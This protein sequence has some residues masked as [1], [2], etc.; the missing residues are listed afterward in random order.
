MWKWGVTG[1]QAGVQKNPWNYSPSAICLCT[2][3]V[4]LCIKCPSR[5]MKYSDCQGTS[6]HGVTTILSSS[7]KPA[8]DDD[9]VPEKSL[10]GSLNMNLSH[11]TVFIAVVMSRGFVLLF[12]VW[13][14]FSCEL[15]RFWSLASF[16]RTFVIVWRF[17]FNYLYSETLM[18]TGL[19]TFLSPVW[20]SCFILM[21]LFFHVTRW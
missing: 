16:R 21:D 8:V 1:K 13:V 9:V 17:I 18:S 4:A 5:L 11:K 6:S 14:Y 15:W 19:C 20:V 3:Q 12:V 2:S 7:W 10:L